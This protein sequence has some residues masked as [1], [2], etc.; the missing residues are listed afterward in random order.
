MVAPILA[1]KLYIP[2]P[3]PKVVLR[4]RLI[5]RLDEASS[6]TGTP[7]VTLISAPAG[8]GKTT[9]VS[10]W[11][12]HGGR[13]TAWLSLDEGDSDPTRFLSYLV[14][15]LQTLA[16]SGVEGVAPNL[17]AGAA[18]MLQAGQSQLPHTEAILTALLNEIMSISKGFLLVL[19]DYHVIDSR[20]VDEA[21]NFLVEHLPP[22]MHLVI[23]TREDPALP[24][25]RL[26]AR[27]QLTELRAADLRF[28]P[29][30]A[31]EFLNQAD[32]PSPLGG[33]GRRTGR[34]N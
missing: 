27:R 2:P 8:F 3:P 10:E 12:A 31:A 24:I 22:Q 13:P 1:T 32:G 11:V 15:A 26:R 16:L 28:T 6:A 17:G 20:L 7:S 33:R 34:P 23:T 4:P 19:D 29:S 25:P 18:E 14:A 21:L 9:L 30:E 5:D